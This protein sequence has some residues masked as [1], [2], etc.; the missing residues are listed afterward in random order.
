MKKWSLLVAGTLI[1]LGA[2]AFLF[3]RSLQ[4][5]ETV[6]AKRSSIK[7]AVYGIGTVMSN[8]R[9]SY[10]PGVAKY[11]EALYVKEGDEVRKGQNLLKISDVGIIHSPINGVVTLLSQKVGENASPTAPVVV[12]EDLHDR[13]ISASLEQQGALR[14]R[15]GLSASLSFESL[16]GQI[17][18]GIVR[19]VFPKNSQFVALIDVQNLPLEI[20]PDMTAD[21]AIE[22]AEKKDVLLIPI[23]ALGSGMVQI[24]DGRS[25]KKVSVKIGLMDEE[26]GE[27]LEGDLK[28]GDLVILPKR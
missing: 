25:R 5:L 13:Y 19:S 10:Q 3:S 9:F 23:R 28:D 17:F 16:R 21:V 12:V 18:T 8:Q 14:V 11:I 20:V 6:A 24:K 1:A 15:K 7:E 26:W 27:V 22:V 2:I 4:N